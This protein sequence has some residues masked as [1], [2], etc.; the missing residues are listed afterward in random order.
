MREKAVF[1]EAKPLEGNDL[2]EGMT[3]ILK[4]KIS[5][6]IFEGQTKTKLGSNDIGPDGPSVRSFIGDFVKRELDN[7][8]HKNPDTAKARTSWRSTISL[9]TRRT[10]C[11][12]T[13]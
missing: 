12:S 11:S 10:S 1:L 2:R 5:N 8:L 3:A 13:G 6:P 7:Y 4:V 9:A